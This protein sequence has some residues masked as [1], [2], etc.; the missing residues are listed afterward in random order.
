[1][2]RN[3]ERT[4]FVTDQ[5]ST[6]TRSTVLSTFSGTKKDLEVRFNKD[7]KSNNHDEEVEST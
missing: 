2:L 3:G 1:M 5:I 7:F 6:R 4:T